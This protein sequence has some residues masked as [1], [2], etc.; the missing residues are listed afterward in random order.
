[1]KKYIFLW[2]LSTGVEYKNGCFEKV[3]KRPVTMLGSDGCIIVDAR[4]NSDNIRKTAIEIVNKNNRAVGFSVGVL[5][6]NDPDNKEAQKFINF[7]RVK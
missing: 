3:E 5:T 4:L 6:C 1:M 2:Q 7:T